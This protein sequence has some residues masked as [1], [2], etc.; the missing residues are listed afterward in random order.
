VVFAYLS[1]VDFISPCHK[2]TWNN[3]IPTFLHSSVSFFL[4]EAA[5]FLLNVVFFWFL[6]VYCT[7]YLVITLWS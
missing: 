6:L 3:N 4:F 1:E 5:L 7:G 2:A